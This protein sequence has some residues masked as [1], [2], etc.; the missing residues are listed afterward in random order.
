M[1]ERELKLGLPGRFVL[2]PLALDGEALTVVPLAELE[3]R[4]SYHDTDDLRLAR[5][6]ASLRHRSGEPAGPHWTL[7]LPLNPRPGELDR[8]ELDFAGERR[9][10][11]AE[12]LDLVTAFVRHA[13]LRPVATLRTRRRRWS[14]RRGDEDVAELDD[15]EVSVLEGRRVVARFRELEVEACAP[16][17]PL[18]LIAEQLT[19]AGA[20]VAEPI[21]KVVRALGSRATT[22]PDV[23]VADLPPTATG[24]ELVAAAIGDAVA[25]IQRHDAPARM[26]LDPEAIHQLRVA[27]RR[28]RSDLRSLAGLL[29]P[30]WLQAIE[31]PLRAL[32]GHLGA[33][34]D[35]DV[36][37]A[38]LEEDAGEQHADLAPLWEE[39]GAR[40]REAH[41]RL[42]VAL[43][44]PEY[45]SLLDE[46]V[47]AHRSPP[48]AEAAAAPAVGAALDLVAGTWQRLDR[49][50]DKLRTADLDDRF[51][52]TRIRA[53][54]AR[55]ATET[56]ARALPAQP[57]AAARRL[58]ARLGDLQDA[59]GAL[60]DGVMGS[61][62]L[63]EAVRARG[64]DASFAFAAGR[65]TERQ[66]QR[67]DEARD[68]FFAIW[69]DVRRARWRR[70]AKA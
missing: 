11:P 16:E 67:A 1:P 12:A 51:H 42:L 10:V 50:A 69:A 58:A 14:V 28:L 36:L 55:Y 3:L 53:K 18:D 39:L 15:D 7:K 59:L 44:D 63:R 19:A 20:T 26:G 40:R 56:A 37:R 25:R 61:E 68:A 48:V 47:S 22:A 30:K 34:R 64:A 24:A 62:L 4:A 70:W 60:Q 6:G 31:P 33:V 2:P 65:L 41:A 52:A 43:R 38:R 66:A 29:D 49:S 21:P 54:R 57:A 45:A 17:A 27:T 35:L 8:Q 13:S 46:L 32:A 23:V 5:H 9:E